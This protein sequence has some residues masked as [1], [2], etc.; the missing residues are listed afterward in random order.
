LWSKCTFHM[1]QAGEQSRQRVT[2]SP[3]MTSTVGGT[4]IL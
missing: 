4:G 1:G 2:Q 3:V